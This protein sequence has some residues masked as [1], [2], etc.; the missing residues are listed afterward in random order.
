MFCA[1]RTTKVS[2]FPRVIVSVDTQALTLPAMAAP[3]LTC[4][5]GLVPADSDACR[6]AILGFYLSVL[7]SCLGYFATEPGESL[8]GLVVTR[9]VAL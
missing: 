9:C 5:N 6:M 8:C 2:T 7:Y 4:M 3:L 1:S